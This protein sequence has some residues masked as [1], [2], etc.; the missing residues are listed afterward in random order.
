MSRFARGFALL[1]IAGLGSMAWGCTTPGSATTAAVE[2]SP[3]P[4]A[5][6]RDL[7]RLCEIATE[8]RADASLTEDEKELAIAQRFADG[9]VERET[10]A[11]FEELAR[12]EPATRYDAI[13]ALAQQHGVAGYTC[14]ALEMNR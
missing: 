2:S 11:F 4:D 12:R 1:L 6:G 7:L 10:Q 14:P 13:V 8:V 3:Q 5:V 9:G